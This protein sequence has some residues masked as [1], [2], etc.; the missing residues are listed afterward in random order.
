LKYQKLELE[1]S[2]AGYLIS[3]K[4]RKKWG[5]THTKHKN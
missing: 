2:F 1:G 4:E 3:G 5:D